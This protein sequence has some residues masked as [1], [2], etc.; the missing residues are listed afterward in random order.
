MPYYLHLKI[1]I[2]EITLLAIAFSMVLFP[3]IAQLKTFMEL[4][5][6]SDEISSTR[7]FNT[8]AL[9]N[10]DYA[11]N[12]TNRLGFN[13]YA[14]LNGK[15]FNHFIVETGM[16]FN[17]RA[18]TKKVELPVFYGN[19]T[20]W[21]TN[22]TPTP[23]ATYNYDLAAMS[24]LMFSSGD[25]SYSMLSETPAITNTASAQS[26]NGQTRIGY[27]SVPIRLYY[28]LF[29]DKL[30]IGVGVVNAFVAFSS[31]VKYAIPFAVST[32]TST[33]NIYGSGSEPMMM[34]Q[35]YHEQH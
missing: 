18:F 32:T 28:S 4:T 15:V 23:P 25:V 31:E 6:N 7:I 12:F 5:G 19:T 14:G 11:V 9:M 29:S 34:Q 35:I 1:L 13:V 21:P 8:Y 20:T 10:E 22:E 17:Y 33:D 3:L 2:Y 27:L 24:E 30:R 26:D 16:A